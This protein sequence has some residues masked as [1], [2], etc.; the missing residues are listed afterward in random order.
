MTARTDAAARVRGLHP[1]LPLLFDALRAELGEP[2]RD[3]SV[4]VVPETVAPQPVPPGDPLGNAIARAAAEPGTDADDLALRLAVAAE[5]VV[6]AAAT[7]GAKA[8]RALG[9][10]GIGD[11]GE[12]A[13]DAVIAVLQ[14]YAAGL[15]AAAATGTQRP[16]PPA[17]LLARVRGVAR[18][19]GV[20]EAVRGVRGWEA[21]QRFGEPHCPR[22]GCYGRDGTVLTEAVVAADGL[23]P[24]GD[25]CNCHTEPAHLG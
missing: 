21:V 6:L 11:V 4:P 12:V 9:A 19:A 8:A 14:P 17:D 5:D 18:S 13:V 24:Y 23:P 16:E 3:R 7:S 10:P 1:P 2:P 22:P 20:V 25:G 15:V